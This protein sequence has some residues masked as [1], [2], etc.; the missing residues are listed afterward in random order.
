MTQ[1]IKNLKLKKLIAENNKN[2]IMS[3]IPAHLT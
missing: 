2:L 1:K 3:D